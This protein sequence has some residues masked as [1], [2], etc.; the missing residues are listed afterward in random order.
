MRRVELYWL[1]I[2]II[3]RIIVINIQRIRKE[4]AKKIR[5]KTLNM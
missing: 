1:D 2:L 4:E 3:S 5:V